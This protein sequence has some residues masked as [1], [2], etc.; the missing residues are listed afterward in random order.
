MCKAVVLTVVDDTVL[1]NLS[2][3]YVVGEFFKALIVFSDEFIF[4]HRPVF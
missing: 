1:Y 3:A 2:K 4:T